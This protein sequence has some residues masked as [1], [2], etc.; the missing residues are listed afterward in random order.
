MA[1]GVAGP[2]ARLWAATALAALVILAGVLAVSLREDE[3]AANDLRLESDTI[4][5]GVHA[6]STKLEFADTQARVSQDLPESKPLE[7]PLAEDPTQVLPALSAFSVGD[8]VASPE[9]N[10]DR[11]V[12]DAEGARQLQDLLWR[13]SSES[14]AIADEIGQHTRDL[15][16]LKIDSGDWTPAETDRPAVRSPNLI[17]TTLRVG[18]DGIAKRVD[19]FQGQSALLDDAIARGKAHPVQCQATVVDF[20]ESK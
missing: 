10:P 12:L 19:I 3:L 14:Q 18:R 6:D 8:C 13:L 2:H 9:L 17:S 4:P 15:V 11:K 5:G 7:L 16:Q 20:F 1:Q